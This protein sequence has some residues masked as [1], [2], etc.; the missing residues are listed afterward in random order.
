MFDNELFNGIELNKEEK[1]LY[2]E[3]YRESFEDKVK[4]A[5]FFS[6]KTEDKVMVH[7]DING[8]YI[9]KKCFDKR[10]WFMQKHLLDKM[11]D[12]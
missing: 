7:D 10:S 5:F 6:C 8:E 9:C 3:K 1:K 12:K 11:K 4:C 2:W